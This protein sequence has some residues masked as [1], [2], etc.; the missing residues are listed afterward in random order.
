MCGEAALL[1]R[2]NQSLGRLRLLGEL[3]NLRHGQEASVERASMFERH[4]H[5][6]DHDV[7]AAT[8]RADACLK[9]DIADAM[10]PGSKSVPE[11][12]VEIHNRVRGRGALRLRAPSLLPGVSD[13]TYM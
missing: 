7:H 8:H 12:L 9:V 2:Q 10:S 13:V 4:R 1:G 6:V 5:L 3:R 11:L